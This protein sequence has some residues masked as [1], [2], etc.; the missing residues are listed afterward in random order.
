MP[1]MLTYDR[2]FEFQSP[3]AFKLMPGKLCRSLVDSHLSFHC[4][5]RLSTVRLQA[6]PEVIYGAITFC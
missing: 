4:P 2:I 5:V 3:S 6:I 1:L